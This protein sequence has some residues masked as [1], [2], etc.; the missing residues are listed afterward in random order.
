[1][2]IEK[3]KAYWCNDLPPTKK[4][5]SLLEAEQLQGCLSVRYQ[6][7]LW[8]HKAL[9]IEFSEFH[10]LVLLMLCCLSSGPRLGLS[11]RPH[12]NKNCDQVAHTG[13]R[14][15]QLTRSS[16]VSESLMS[17]VLCER[18]HFFS[19]LSAAGNQK[20]VGLPSTLTVL[21]S[22]CERLREVVSATVVFRSQSHVEVH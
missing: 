8:H 17:N 22:L 20:S 6:R 18:L 15:Q 21:H 13:H 9:G 12:R 19:R 11:E 3:E 14:H 2:S 5:K 1:M 16:L 7:S 4:R 10:Q